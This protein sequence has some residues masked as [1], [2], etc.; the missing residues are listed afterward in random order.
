MIHM[1]VFAFYARATDVTSVD[2]I[3]PSYHYLGLRVLVV[4][5]ADSKTL[6]LSPMW[7]EPRS[8]HM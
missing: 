6:D 5:H 4:K 8:G 1:K 2:V 7:F 3:R